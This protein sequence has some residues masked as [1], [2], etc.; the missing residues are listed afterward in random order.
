[1][2]ELA[3]E[4]TGSWRIATTNTTLT[5]FNITLYPSLIIPNLSVALIDPDNVE[6]VR[7][8]GEFQVNPRAQKASVQFVL[9]R[10]LR[11]IVVIIEISQSW[12]CHH[13][14]LNFVSPKCRF[15]V[16]ELNYQSQSL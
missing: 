10:L 1:M 16:F 5:D 12:W 14:S 2:W 7:I 15:L 8:F 4:F 9:L 11:R 6:L 3:R 13:S